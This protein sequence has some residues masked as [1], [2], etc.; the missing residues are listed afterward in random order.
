MSDSYHAHALAKDVDYRFGYVTG[1]ANIAAVRDKISRSAITDPAL[2]SAVDQLDTYFEQLESALG[3]AVFNLAQRQEVQGELLDDADA[4]TLS[5]AE[6][7]EVRT[8]IDKREAMRL[9]TLI[10]ERSRSWK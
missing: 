1:R 9:A 5:Q 6:K 10:G 4:A 2:I 8:T 7:A 3:E